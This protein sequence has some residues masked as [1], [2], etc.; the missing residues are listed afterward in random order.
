MDRKQSAVHRMVSALVMECHYPHYAKKNVTST[1]R[2]K[3]V[4]AVP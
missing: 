4:S 2:K 3:G 1:K